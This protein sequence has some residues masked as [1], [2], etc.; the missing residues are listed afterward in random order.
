[1][2]TTIHGYRLS[3]QQKRLWSRDCARQRSEMFLR[4]EGDLDPD[5]LRESLRVLVARHSIL[6]TSFEVPEGV[7]MPVQVVNSASD[8][9]Q[10][11]LS[12]NGPK[13]FSLSLSAPLLCADS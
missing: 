3:P 10:G 11:K 7:S 4:L 8:G 12:Q 5:R 1:M 13:S 9:F 2:T 6:R